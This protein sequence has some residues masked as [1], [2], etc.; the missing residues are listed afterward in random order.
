MPPCLA[1]A[2]TEVSFCVFSERICCF[3]KF[4]E[5]EFWGLFLGFE[6]YRE[7]EV[8]G[9]IRPLKSAC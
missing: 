1:F 2:G 6:Y 4:S 9:K 5:N 7:E 8:S 3:F